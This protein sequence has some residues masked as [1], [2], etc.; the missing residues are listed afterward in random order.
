MSGRVISRR[1]SGH[2]LSTTGA[3]SSS[4]GVRFSSAATGGKSSHSASRQQG[5]FA[6]HAS[7]NKA[8]A[9]G[10]S[11]NKNH[12]EVA[13]ISQNNAASTTTTANGGERENKKLIS[14]SSNR[15]VAANGSIK[16]SKNSSIGGAGKSTSG[17]LAVKLCDNK[18]TKS[19][20]FKSD[21]GDD[22]KV[23]KR[24][25]EKTARAHHEGSSGFVTVLEINNTTSNEDLWNS[26][27]A[28]FIFRQSS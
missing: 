22:K 19:V 21:C 16:P 28:G 10:H 13:T 18:K 2:Q 3:T 24:R 14:T 4:A 27:K 25:T 20:T 11:G 7:L 26:Y 23:A 17:K 5:T 6:S 12:L 1:S 9:T 8:E 15:T